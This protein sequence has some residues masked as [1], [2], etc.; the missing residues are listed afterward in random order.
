MNKLLHLLID[1]EEIVWNN[2]SQVREKIRCK[3]IV[4]RKEQ[5]ECSRF[6]LNKAD[7]S[8]SKYPKTNFTSKNED[9][10]HSHSSD[11]DIIYYK[12]EY[13]DR[14]DVSEKAKEI[15]MILQRSIS[16]PNEDREEI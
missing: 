10:L 5:R 14:L 13:G 1:R 4:R 16:L 8:R 15:A 3:V 6:P 7:L 9:F 2:S 11:V 12:D